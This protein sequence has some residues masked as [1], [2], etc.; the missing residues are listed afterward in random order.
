MESLSRN[1]GKET[2]STARILDLTL[3]ECFV[4]ASPFVFC[5][6]EFFALKLNV[7]SAK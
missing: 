1:M 5:C 3:T 6:L 4:R 7:P 2:E